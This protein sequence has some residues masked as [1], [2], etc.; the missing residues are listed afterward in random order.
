MI[1]FGKK[2]RYIKPVAESTAIDD[3]ATMISGSAPDQGDGG[4]HGTIDRAAKRNVFFG[5]VLEEDFIEEE[6]EVWGYE[7][8]SLW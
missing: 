8:E 4:E 2:K 7:Y 6:N 1:Y 5:E 3:E